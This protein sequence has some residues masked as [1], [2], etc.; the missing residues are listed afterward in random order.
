MC[1]FHI[2]PK[3]DLELL[4]YFALKLQ[5]SQLCLAIR[6]PPSCAHVNDVIFKMVKLT[7]SENKNLAIIMQLSAQDYRY[8]HFV[9][10]STNQIEVEALAILREYDQ[11]PL[12]VSKPFQD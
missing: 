8:L 11:K 1:H 7:F 10:P 12:K 4:S 9:L 2:R 3:N 5:L 6:N